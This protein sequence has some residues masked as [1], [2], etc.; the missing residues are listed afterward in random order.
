MR[1]T[2]VSC[3]CG[4]MPPF[5]VTGS[6]LI[7][8]RTQGQKRFK[9]AD[10]LSSMNRTHSLILTVVILL[11]GCIDQAAQTENAAQ[12]GG[13]R[14]ASWL[15]Q[16]DA[17]ITSGKPFSLVM[18]GWVTPEE[19]QAFKRMNSRVTL[20]A[21]VSVNWVYDSREWRQFL[22]TIASGDG[23][24]RTIKE[25]MFL[26][27]PDGKKCAFGWAS[28]EWDH[29]EIYAMNPRDPEWVDLILSA[30]QTLLDQPQH[31]GVFVDMVMNVSWCPAAITNEEWSS[32][33]REILK[34]IKE[35]A[36]ARGKVVF[37]NAGRD[38]SEV[39]QYRSYMDGYLMEN[40][41]GSW[42]ADFDTGLRAADSGYTVVY[43]ADTDDTGV[44]DLKRMR[45][46]LTLSLLNDNT[47]FTYDFGPRIH[48]QAWWFPEYDAI[49]GK[50][51]GHYYEKDNAYWR[52]F[53]RGLVISSPYTEATVTLG[54]PHTD[55]TTG[56]TSTTFVVAKGDGR[57]L[58]KAEEP[59]SFI[60]GVISSLQLSSGAIPP[61]FNR[62]SRSFSIVFNQRHLLTMIFVPPRI[63]SIKGNPGYPSRCWV[64]LLNFGPLKS[65]GSTTR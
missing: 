9:D 37:F 5:V 25:T 31:D 23:T 22:E 46:G 39:D 47:F 59:T 52:E 28:E 35:M 24:Q 10:S 51:L 38:L 34:E 43:A 8:G 12:Q 48:G 6:S 26:K 11:A 2:S 33:T 50:P 61:T 30:Y 20:L 14:I 57:I 21:G 17:L 45:L 62:I 29:Q 49:L 42:G 32:A 41:L 64:S 1:C 58:V 40:F 55:V 27:G 19:A 18:T 16:K 15:S 54:E 60:H 7:W 53:E 44:K 13:T 65:L 56:L 63:N 4:P 36:E 3:P